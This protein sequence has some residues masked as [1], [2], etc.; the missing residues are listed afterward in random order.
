MLALIV[1]IF[2]FLWFPY[3]LYFSVLYT[4]LTSEYDR[5]TSLYIYLNIY[6]LGMSSTIF[7]PII[8]YFMNERFILFFFLLLQLLFY[9]IW[10]YSIA[11]VLLNGLI[12]DGTKANHKGKYQSKVIINNK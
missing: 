9:F 8:Y 12:F 3:Q 6:W 10:K 4:H 1:F 11:E 7:N 2:M 5:K